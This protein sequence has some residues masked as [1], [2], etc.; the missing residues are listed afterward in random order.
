ML[1]RIHLPGLGLLRALVTL[2][3]VL[4]PLVGASPCYSRSDDAA[5]QADIWINGSG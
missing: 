2:P 4:P 3:L 5:S 1:A